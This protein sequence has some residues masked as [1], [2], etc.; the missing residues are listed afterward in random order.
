VKEYMEHRIVAACGSA[1]KTRHGEFEGKIE[2]K[3][4]DDEE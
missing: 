3:T 4:G 1:V 2:D